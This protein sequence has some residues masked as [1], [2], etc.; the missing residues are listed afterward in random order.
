MV[1]GS[2]ANNVAKMPFSATTSILASR[3]RSGK[4]LV[5]G[6]F[7]A[8][9]LLIAAAPLPAANVDRAFRTPKKSIDPYLTDEGMTI[10]R[11]NELIYVHTPKTGGSSVGKS[12]LFDDARERHPIGGHYRIEAM[13]KDRKDR[14][15]SN[16]RT[17]THVRHP[18]TRFVSAYGY[19]T[20]DLCNDLDKAW[21]AKNVGDKSL[22][23]F[24]RHAL[25]NPKTRIWDHF[26]P[27]HEW[28]FYA[29]GTYGIDLTMCQ[30]TWNGSLDRLSDLLGKAVPPGLY[31]EHALRNP[32]RSCA[33]LDPETR[34]VIERIYALDYCIFEYE[35]LP[36]TDDGC[37][38][39]D[40]TKE[41][42][43]DRYERCKNSVGTPPSPEIES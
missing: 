31:R 33:D 7:A 41:E 36:K 30:E 2:Q 14:G 42:M 22:D 32:H 3:R 43:T 24:A 38:V 39:A 15:L 6:A 1:R 9:L 34:E 16:F 19:L 17:A 28:L 35:S 8:A 18:C 5:G 29:D 20:S 12:S 4:N 37:T 23:E 13:T 26:K 27:L 10:S 25:N 11:T 40:R 21:A